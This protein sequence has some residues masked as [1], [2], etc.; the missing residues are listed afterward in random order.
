MEQ[1][2]IGRP[3][4]TPASAA[5]RARISCW[6]C[7][8]QRWRGGSCRRWSRML[9]CDQ[10]M[11]AEQGALYRRSLRSWR[12]PR[13]AALE[14]ARPASG[15]PGAHSGT[16]PLVF[17]S[18]AVPDESQLIERPDPSDLPPGWDAIPHSRTSAAF[19]GRW[20]REAGQLALVLPS[21][22][23]LLARIDLP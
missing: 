9:R 20:L 14:S 19:G 7:R 13:W 2:L 5:W 18:Y 23:V 15:L 3:A 17:C 21:V 11:A 16:A 8:R 12:R 22:V 1:P 6:R 4:R 10:G